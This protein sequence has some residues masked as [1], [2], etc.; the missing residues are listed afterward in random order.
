MRGGGVWRFGGVKGEKQARLVVKIKFDLNIFGALREKEIVMSVT[1]NEAK[2]IFELPFMD[3]IMRAQGVLRENFPANVIQTSTLLSIKTGACSEDCAYCAQSSYS[4]APQPAKKPKI[5][6]REAVLT[7]AKRAKEAGS[8]RFCMGA[9]GRS[10]SDEEVEEVCDI[11]REVKGL[12]MEVC[13]TLGLLSESQAQ[14]LKAAGLDFY[15]HNIDTS[16]EFYSQVI[17]TRTFEERLQTISNVR[18]AGV[19]LC[20]GGII[21][22]G[23][24]N[25]A[26]IKML[27]TLANLPIP[28]ESVPINKLVKIPGTNLQDAPEVDKFDFVR[29]IALARILMPKSYVRLSAGRAQMSE[30]LQ[31]LCL[32]AGANS[33]FY[34]DKLL[35]A[36]NAAPTRDEQLFAKLNL[37]RE[38]FVEAKDF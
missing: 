9:S 3:L 21:G 19:K 14:K 32:L 16:K 15:N 7:L 11:V 10:P 33:L 28:P 2:E 30:E 35:T 4:N 22:L 27:V 5:M 29:T 12:G 26:R 37:K 8:S 25:D 6:D 34:G 20:V 31:A 1:F 36:N 38:V 23:E 24:D 18:E 17:T 13:V